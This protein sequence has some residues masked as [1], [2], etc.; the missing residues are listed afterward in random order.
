MTFTTCVSLHP[1]LASEDSDPHF[2]LQLDAGWYRSH[3][4]VVSQEPRLFASTVAANISYGCQGLNDVSRAD[5]EHAAKLSNAYEFILK[6]PQ[7]FDTPVTD[8]REC[9]ETP[10]NL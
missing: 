5:V 6:L 10:S 4:G 3:V 7:G 2:S 8:K 9:H 1:C